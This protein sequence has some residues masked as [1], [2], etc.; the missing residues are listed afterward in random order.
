MTERGKRGRLRRERGSS[1]NKS[2]PAQLSSSSST[3]FEDGGII[4]TIALINMC[5]S[6]SVI[7]QSARTELITLS[8]M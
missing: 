8:Q 1:R 4:L 6:V 7:N 5:D 2:R 3:P